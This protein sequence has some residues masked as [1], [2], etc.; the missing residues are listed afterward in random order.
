MLDQDHQ[1]QGLVENEEISAKAYVGV[2]NAIAGV[3]SGSGLLV[4]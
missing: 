3:G 1:D 2:A 4:G